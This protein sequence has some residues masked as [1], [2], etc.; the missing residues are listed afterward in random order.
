MKEH[1]GDLEK[2]IEQRRGKC[3]SSKVY[4]ELLRRNRILEDQVAALRETLKAMPASPSPS[5]QADLPD[6]S[7]WGSVSCSPPAPEAVLGSFPRGCHACG[8]GS[9]SSSVT[10][11]PAW[12]LIMDR[13]DAFLTPPAPLPAVSMPSASTTPANGTFDA[14]AVGMYSFSSYGSCYNSAG[15]ATSIQ[16][17]VNAWKSEIQPGVNAWKSDGLYDQWSV[18]GFR[19]GFGVQDFAWNKDTYNFQDVNAYGAKRVVQATTSS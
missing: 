11:A 3:G 19:V 16:P 18:D 8:S 10:S 9:I 7:E 17:G 12:P 1:I 6:L 2:E 14:G 13:N 15:A 5:S 4:Q